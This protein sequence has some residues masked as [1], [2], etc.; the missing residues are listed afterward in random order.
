MVPSTSTMDSLV[1]LE[2]YLTIPLL[3]VVSLTNNTTCS[4]CTQVLTAEDVQ[5]MT[6]ERAFA[7]K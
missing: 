4:Q 2:A 3:M 1:K 6:Q 5:S 7:C